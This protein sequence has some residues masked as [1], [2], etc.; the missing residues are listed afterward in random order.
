MKPQDKIL[1]VLG[2][3]AIIGTAGFGGYSL[4]TSGHS[5]QTSSVPVVTKTATT[6]AP[7]SSSST[8]TTPESETEVETEDEAATPSPVAAPTTPAP[9][10]PAPSP[11]AT[12]TGSHRNGTYTATVSYNVPDG[13]HNTLNATVTI[14]N[15]TISAVTTNNSYTER[16]SQQYVDSFANGISSASVGKPVATF[17]IGRVGGASLTSAAFNSALDTIRNEAKA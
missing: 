11:A 1:V 12:P 8:P 3:A 7:D 5:A 9:T 13:G 6:T 15:S 2:S 4:F 16:K 17:S 10:T 14:S